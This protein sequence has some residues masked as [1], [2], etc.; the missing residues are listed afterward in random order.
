MTPPVDWGDDRLSTAIAPLTTETGV[1]PGCS[2]VVV[3]VGGIVVAVVGGGAVAFDG[4]IVP[5][6]ADEHP[7]AMSKAAVRPSAARRLTEPFA[8]G[9]DRST[10]A[11][12]CSELTSWTVS[13]G[14]AQPDGRTGAHLPGGIHHRGRD[15]DPDADG[16]ANADQAADDLSADAEVDPSTDGMSVQ[17]WRSS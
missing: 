5:G 15:R 14:I 2:V 11:V 17:S 7:A 16:D 10:R 9:F 12:T 13:A 3:V 4:A 6:T 1:H 8:S